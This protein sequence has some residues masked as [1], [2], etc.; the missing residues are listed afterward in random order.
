MPSADNAA[1]APSRGE[2]YDMVADA[3]CRNLIA[4]RKPKKSAPDFTGEL[5]HTE[6]DDNIWTAQDFQ[7]ENLFDEGDLT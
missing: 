5:R 3:R 6:P 1:D 4:S 2:P 7:L